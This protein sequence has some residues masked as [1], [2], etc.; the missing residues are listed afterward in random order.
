MCARLR[1]AVDLPRSATGDPTKL[2]VITVVGGEAGFVI[3]DGGKAGH[4]TVTAAL[5]HAL[6]SVRPGR[7]LSLVGVASRA[8]QWLRFEEGTR[9]WMSGSVAQNVTFDVCAN[10]SR[11]VWRRAAARC[12]RTNLC[13]LH[14]VS[15]H[16][17]SSRE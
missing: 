10:V 8:M 7:R 4:G 13:G 1:S 5:L 11:Y 12:C 16:Y 3:P 14:A 9:S 2:S 15:M 17:G 6:R